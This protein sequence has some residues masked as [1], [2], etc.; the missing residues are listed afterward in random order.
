MSVSGDD[1]VPLLVLVLPELC[2]LIQHLKSRCTNSDCPGQKLASK[3]GQTGCACGYSD[4]MWL[5]RCT[6]MAI[7]VGH[8]LP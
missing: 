3:K 2:A 4:A 7:I 6:P 1:L 8:S 5:F